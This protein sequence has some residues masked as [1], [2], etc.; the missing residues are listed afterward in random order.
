MKVTGR[1][2]VYICMDWVNPQGRKNVAVPNA[3]AALFS[4]PMILPIR[5]CARPAER[6]SIN[7]PRFAQGNTFN[8][9]NSHNHHHPTNHDTQVPLPQ[10]L[11]IET[12]NQSRPLPH[13]STKNE[14]KRL[15]VKQ[16][17]WTQFLPFLGIIG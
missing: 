15:R 11:Q 12:Q 3:R 13:P 17:L 16:E 5:E 14:I 1:Q 9:P 2:S 8:R 4:S 7:C 10:K 6:G